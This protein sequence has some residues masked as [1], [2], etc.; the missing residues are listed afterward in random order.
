LA[1]QAELTAQTCSCPQAAQSMRALT[2]GNLRNTLGS[3]SIAVETVQS[4]MGHLII[5]ELIADPLSIV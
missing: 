4:V 3:T 1:S 2:L 5:T